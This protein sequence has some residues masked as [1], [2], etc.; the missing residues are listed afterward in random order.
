MLRRVYGGILPRLR[1]IPDVKA[2]GATNT[3]PLGPFSFAENFLVSWSAKRSR[4]WRYLG[5]GA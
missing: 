3:L 2:A 4:R 5:Q 1:S